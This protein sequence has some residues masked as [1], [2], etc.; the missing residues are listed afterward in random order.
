[1]NDELYSFDTTTSRP[2]VRL[3]PPVPSGSGGDI[4]E[5]ELSPDATR[6]LLLSGSIDGNVYQLYS[7]PFD[8][9]A[10]AI[11]IDDPGTRGAWVEDFIIS[12]DSGWA[13]YY[14]FKAQNNGWRLYSRPV[15][16]GSGER[17]LSG[18][19]VR[20]GGILSY[21]VSAD[22][23]RVVYV[24]DQLAD[25][26]FELFSVPIDGSTV[27]VRLNGPLV[28]NGDTHYRFQISADSNWVVYTADQAEDERF[29]VYAVRID[30]SAAPV[31]LNG[32]LVPGG[33]AGFLQR[34]QP[35]FLSSSDSR[36][37]FYVADQDSDEVFQLYSVRID[38]G[39]A[40]VK[41]N[42]PLVAGGDVAHASDDQVLF[43][44]SPDGADVLYAADQ[45]TDEK[46][47]LYAAP[48]DGRGPPVKLNGALPPAGD[49]STSYSA[50]SFVQFTADG[51]T[52]LY[53][54]DQETD[55]TQE[56][57]AAPIDGSGTVKKLNG[58][59]PQGGDVLSG[60]QP[61][62]RGSS[63]F[64]VADQRAN[65]V[66]EL[67]EAPLDGSGVSQ[68]INH[69]PTSGGDILVPLS[70]PVFRVTPDG[71]AVIYVA[72][73]DTDDVFEIYEALLMVV[74]RR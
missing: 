7:V 32:P 71:R 28:P 26:D 52:V 17:D 53:L 20:F 68:R 47:E 6:V 31:K 21:A 19:L 70:G 3:V 1:V 50:R 35:Q 10:P 60:F 59:L 24:A 45:E 15:D 12:P 44:L 74:R 54:A 65:D 8:G 18:A 49:V 56:L 63:V 55:E 66:F 34:D 42:G 40:P 73:Q 13:V 67:F 38:G 62:P 11:R 57:F 30:G 4:I 48:V 27:P 41:L 23:R 61:N 22:S 72:D 58:P 9:G 25:Q 43:R 29:E 46:L 16:V 39:S 33:D 51:N 2:P 5:Y 37:V 69:L 64:Y 36:R 14:G